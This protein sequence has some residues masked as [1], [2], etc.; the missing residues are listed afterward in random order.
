MPIN[1]Y[2]QTENKNIRIVWLSDGDWELPSQI[3]TFEKWLIENEI[4]LPKGSYVADIGFGLRKDACGGGGAVTLKMME[5]ML[6]VGMEL[7]LS[8]YPDGDENS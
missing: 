4:K 2:N 7:Y 8:E 3:D 1:I 5:I 6:R